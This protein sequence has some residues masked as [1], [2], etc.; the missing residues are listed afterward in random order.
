MATYFITGATGSVGKE[1]VETLL[2][3]NQQVIAGNLKLSAWLST[4]LKSIYQA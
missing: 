4:Q 3:Q 2:A 1:V